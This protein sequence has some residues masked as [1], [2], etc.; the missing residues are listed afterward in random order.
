MSNCADNN[1][2]MST[3]DVN[4]CLVNNGGCEETCTNTLGSFQCSCDR[5]DLYTLAAD[6]FT[7]QRKYMGSFQCSCDRNDLYT[8]AADG[9]TCQRKYLGSFQCSCDRSDLYAPTCGGLTVRPIPCILR[10]I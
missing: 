4:E 10:S 5:S 1:S 3:Q 7:C 8:L 9:F 6:G 2:A